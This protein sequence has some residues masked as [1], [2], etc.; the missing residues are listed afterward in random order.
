MDEDTTIRA[1]FIVNN[2]AEARIYGTGRLS[3][4]DVNNSNIYLY[5]NARLVFD[6]PTVYNEKGGFNIGSGATLELRSG[7]YW[8]GFG[9]VPVW[10]PD[11]LRRRFL[12]PP[13]GAL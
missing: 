11:C 5:P 12:Q 7:S 8:G 9:R 1:Q 13:P 2:S 6:G 10:Q 3:I 4:L